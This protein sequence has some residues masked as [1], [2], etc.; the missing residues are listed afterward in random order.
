MEVNE[1]LRKTKVFALLPILVMATVFGALLFSVSASED[2][3]IEEEPT[4]TFCELRNRWQDSLTDDQLATLQGI[5]EENRAEIQSQL[6]TWALELSELDEEEREW[7][8]T[9]ID[10]NRVEI[11]AQLEAWGIESPMWQGPMD[12]LKSLTNEQKE[13]LQTMKQKLDA[14]NAKLEKREFK[15]QMLMAQTGLP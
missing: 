10:E 13:E 3:T 9:T 6:E 14:V 11:Q 5:I 7:L 12:L 15:S 8:K 4:L 1:I 2:V